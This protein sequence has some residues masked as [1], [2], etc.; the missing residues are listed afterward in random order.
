M[1]QKGSVIDAFQDRATAALLNGRVVPVWDD[2]GSMR[3]IAPQQWHRFFLTVGFKAIRANLNRELA[4]DGME[5]PADESSKHDPSEQ[6]VTST[7]DPVA[8]DLVA[9]LPLLDPRERWP[10]DVPLTGCSRPD[11]AREATARLQLR[12]AQRTA[13]GSTISL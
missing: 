2:R 10:K 11:R 6:R 12:I 5:K 1:M 8:V 13:A 3:F 4:L 7:D 9:L